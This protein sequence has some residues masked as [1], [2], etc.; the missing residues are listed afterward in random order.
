MR[1]LLLSIFLLALAV[2]SSTAQVYESVC[3]DPLEQYRYTGTVQRGGVHMTSEGT[4]RVLV[5]FV[6][7]PGDTSWP[8]NPDWPQ[9]SPPAFGGTFIDPEENEYVDPLNLS[10]YYRD[11]SFGRFTLLGDTVV[12]VPLHPWSHYKS[13]YGQEAY[14][15]VNHEI[16]TSIDARVDFTRYDNWTFDWYNHSAAPD[17]VVDLIIMYYRDIGF[18]G[19]GTG[20]AM[21]RLPVD[22]VADGK[23]ILGWFPGSGLT[24]S[25]HPFKNR[26]GSVRHELGHYL[27]GGGHPRHGKNQCGEADSYGFW[28]I[29]GTNPC[30]AITGFERERLKWVDYS[31]VPAS[32][33]TING[34]LTDFMTTGLVKRIVI[35][36]Q[37]QAFLIE[38]HQKLS[39]FDDPN[40]IWPGKGMF[41]Y[42]V[43]GLDD[44][45]PHYEPMLAEGDFTWSNPYWMYYVWTGG[46][47]IPV[48]RK[49]MANRNGLDGRDHVPHTKPWIRGGCFRVFA[50]DVNGSGW[51]H[52]R[53]WGDEKDPFN[54]GYNQ[55]FSPWSNPRAMTY[56][57]VP[58]PVAVEI[59][60]RYTGGQGEDIFTMRYFNQTAVQLS[61]PSK[62]INL[63]ASVLESGGDRHVRLTWSTNEEPDVRSG[64]SYIIERRKKAGTPNWEIWQYKATMAGMDSAWTDTEI[65]TAGTGSDSLQYRI[66]AT[67]TQ[68]KSSVYSDPASIR[69]DRYLWKL[70][71]DVKPVEFGLAQPYPNPF[72]PSTNI[73]FS[74]E[75]DGWADLTVFNLLGQ[76]VADLVHG[77][78][79]AGRHTVVFD[80]ADLAPGLYFCRLQASG[81][82]AVQKLLLVK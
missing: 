73:A 47:S 65:T 48:F 8:G 41:I 7:F 61:S 76:K 22:I 80:A 37:D 3:A 49:E 26:M 10:A 27:F 78:T 32:P 15:W 23:T 18:P 11:A 38:N 33:D 55:V 74:L 75:R 9:G 53:N 54:V 19:D 24:N 63:R 43:D 16:L 20:I 14:G 21:L 5:V 52:A 72:N 79:K 67:D 77:L 39:P 4:I 29:M 2:C 64:G 70:P 56:Q 69:Y 82:T 35:P 50:Q 36:G 34:V 28:G 60:G 25:W 44:P 13:L 46:D 42:R 1:P 12:A 68:S 51:F 59:T 57:G 58:V 31:D 40:S 62:P 30:L 45:M 66:K 6:Q 17:G 81:A 71:N